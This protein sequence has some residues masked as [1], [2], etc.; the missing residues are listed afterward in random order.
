VALSLNNLAVAH[1]KAGRSDE[2]KALYA[3]ALAAW[4][5]S[6]GPDHPDVGRPLFGLATIAI[7][8]GRPADAVPLL[9]RALRVREAA[10]IDPELVAAARFSLAQA[11]WNADQDRTRAIA[12]ARTALAEHRARGPIGAETVAIV[13]DWL[14]QHEP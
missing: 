4:E 3:R 12:L 1:G 14:A 5:G 10:D 7:D 2:A 8:E 9:E 6:V 13:E 11:L